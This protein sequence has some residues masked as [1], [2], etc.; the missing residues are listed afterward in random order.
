LQAAGDLIEPEA[1]FLPQRRRQPAGGLVFRMA[2]AAV[3][4]GEGR[5]PSLHEVLCQQAERTL[6]LTGGNREAAAR[7][8]DVDLY[9]LQHRLHRSGVADV[10]IRHTEHKKAA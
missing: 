6:E 1:V 2:E 8:L 5:W 9:Q 3:R 10:E 4:P 7:L